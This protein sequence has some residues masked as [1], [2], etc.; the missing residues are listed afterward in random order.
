MEHKQEIINTR[1]GC[2]GGSDARMLM[3]IADIGSIGAA[4]FVGTHLAGAL[5]VLPQPSGINALLQL[6]VFDG[7]ADFSN[8]KIKVEHGI[9]SYYSFSAMPVR[10][11]LS[12]S[13]S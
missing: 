7:L 11:M 4:V 12:K 6:M 2:L 5:F 3:S 1:K 13:S 8:E 9:A 10:S